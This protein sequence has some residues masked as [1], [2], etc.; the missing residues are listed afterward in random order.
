VGDWAARGVVGAY[1]AALA[2]LA[3]GLDYAGL[4]LKFW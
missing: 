2:A 3:V 4:T 1:L